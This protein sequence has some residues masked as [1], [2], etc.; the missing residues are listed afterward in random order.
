[1]KT[2]EKFQIIRYVGA[3]GFLFLYF[4]MSAQ[5]QYRVSGSV[6]NNQHAPEF[7]ELLL[8]DAEDESQQK[9]TTAELGRFS[10]SSISPGNYILKVFALGFLD[11]E[12]ILELAEDQELEIFL[13][14][15]PAFELDEIV[16]VGKKRIFSNEN[17]NLKVNVASSILSS[18]PN[19]TDLLS[20]LPMIQAS[21]DGQSINYIGRGAP[22]IY[23]NNQSISLDQLNAISVQDINT[24]ELIRNPSAKYEA[25]GR[26]VILVSLK[27]NRK[28][29][30]SI[31]LS[32]TASAK[33]AFGN[34]LGISSDFRKNK[35]SLK[36]NVGY[37][38]LQPW[39]QVVSEFELASDN[40]SS[41]Y[42][43][44]V[45][46]DR[47]MIILGAGLF[48]QLDEEQY[49][50]FQVNSTTR[51]AEGT[52]ITP[53]I[54]RNA[55]E[56]T[57]V[58]TKTQTQDNRDLFNSTFNYN[59]KWANSN[60][61][62]GAQYLNY[63]LVMDSHVQ[64]N[65]N[66]TGLLPFQQRLQDFE[67]NVYSGRID[68][69]KDVSKN[70]KLELGIN[71]SFSDAQTLVRFEDLNNPEN[72]IMNTYKLNENILAGYTQWLMSLESFNL[73]AGLRIENADSEGGFEDSNELIIDRMNT[74]LFPKVN[75]NFPIDSLQSLTFDYGRSILRPNFSR[76]S[77]NTFYVNPFT[78]ISQ[79]SDL[80]PTLID[81]VSANY[82]VGNKSLTLSYNYK[83]DPVFYN[84]VYDTESKIYDL[85]PINFE[86]ESGF[87]ISLSSP[88][89]S[90][91]WTS[92]NTLS[93]ISNQILDP[94]GLINDASPYLYFYT[95]NEFRLPRK[96]S[97][98]LSSWGFTKR[99]EGLFERNAITTFNL[100]I[101]KTFFDK[102]NCA[103]AFNDIFNGINYEEESTL[104]E[105][106]STNIF[107]VD[108]REVAFTIKYMFGTD[109]SRYQNR[110]VYEYEGRVR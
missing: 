47:T 21:A 33:Y 97:F 89:E 2:E 24:I 98:S 29:G 11:H 72:L 68:L 92:S 80:K 64:N 27:K 46:G 52:A 25:E 63:N 5:E 77:Q 106:Q 8:L 49:F 56:L 91:S 67:I 81:E 40:L 73:S 44:T 65:I 13:E 39:E 9:Y 38:Q 62:V 45:T 48:Y 16:V 42:M 110:K 4:N 10:F 108:S 34:Y 51:R 18:V 79:N 57:N 35:L 99:K 75:L 70:L 32:E 3:I 6:K 102:L 12:I 59:K 69:E 55:S 1:M 85:T 95:S 53:S 37:N 86:R 61:F 19:P 82:Q 60:L 23:L 103:L 87:Q 14:P 71:S 78:V 26:T 66:N 22:L 20:K 93:F 105:I 54:F 90:G 83:R 41:S 17:G 96:F 30:Y 94:S 104:N 84:V 76:L 36:A 58:L 109:Q 7:A 101:S 31:N 50:S 100:A 88:F 107:N 43:A 28:D 15:D 74:Y